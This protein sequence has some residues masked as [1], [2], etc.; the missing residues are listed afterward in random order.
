MEND[1]IT[2]LVRAYENSETTGF[3]ILDAIRVWEKAERERERRRLDRKEA[4]RRVRAAIHNE[5]LVRES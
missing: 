2:Y 1:T 4:F 3:S 5:R